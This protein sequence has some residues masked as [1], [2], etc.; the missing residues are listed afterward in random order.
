MRGVCDWLPLLPAVTTTGS[1]MSTPRV[2][3]LVLLAAMALV[4]G[5]FL[6]AVRP[7]PPTPCGTP[8]GPPVTAPRVRLRDG[9]YLAYAESGV[10]RDRARFKVVYS[11]GFSG[12]RMD[13]PRASQVGDG[14]LARLR[15]TSLSIFF[16]PHACMYACASGRGNHYHKSDSALAL[17]QVGGQHQLHLQPRAG[18]LSP[19]QVLELED[20][21]E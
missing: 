19:I 13:S 5:W 3:L 15:C 2:G 17:E 1:T 12:G 4:A 7:P 6:N 9:R 8:G 14:G 18:R 10:S 20:E 21:A 16:L 11:H